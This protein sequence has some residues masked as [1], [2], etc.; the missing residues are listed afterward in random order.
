FSPLALES[1]EEKGKSPLPSTAP[2]T[3]EGNANR[4]IVITFEAYLNPAPKAL[5]SEKS[6]KASSPSSSAFEFEY[7]AW[8]EKNPEGKKVGLAPEVY[9]SSDSGRKPSPNSSDL[10]SSLVSKP[11]PGYCADEKGA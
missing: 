10:K 5:K 4:E 8:G 9:S 2:L 7:E 11:P 3:Q 1:I 6:S